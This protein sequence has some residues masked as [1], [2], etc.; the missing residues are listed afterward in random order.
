M[1]SSGSSDPFGIPWDKSNLHFRTKERMVT[2]GG[3]RVG[4]GEGRGRGEGG[5]RGAV[6]IISRFGE[7]Y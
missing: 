1:P 4:M 5:R 6:R 3:E 7:I 2:Q